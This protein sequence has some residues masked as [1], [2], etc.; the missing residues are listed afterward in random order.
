M[1]RVEREGP[2]LDQIP[3]VACP[4]EGGQQLAIVGGPLMLIRLE[5]GAVEGQGFPAF[6][7]PLLQDASN[8][9]V[10]CVRR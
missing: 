10:G 9:L 5:L 6:G 8:H 2:T 4:L 1:I 3:E 7:A